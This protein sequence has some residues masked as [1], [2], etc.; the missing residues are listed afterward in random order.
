[1]GFKYFYGISANYPCEGLQ[2]FESI[3]RMSEFANQ[4]LL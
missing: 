1:M 3:R 4:R 2:T